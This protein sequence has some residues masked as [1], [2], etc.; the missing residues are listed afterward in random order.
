MKAFSLQ[1]FCA[2]RGFSS[3][4]Y[5]RP[6]AQTAIWLCCCYCLQADRERLK[7]ERA[8]AEALLAKEAGADDAL[9]GGMDEPAPAPSPAP[10][11]APAPSPSP[12]PAPAPAKAAEKPEE[13]PEPATKAKAPAPAPA[14][15][16]AQTPAAIPEGVPPATTENVGIVGSKETGGK[17]FYD[18][19]WTD[20][21]GTVVRVASC[22]LQ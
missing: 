14:A 10:S 12:D 22:S 16:A 20:A 17:T 8:A 5:L 11:P 15:S 21:A 18:I 2:A 3:E 19:R 1:D 4:V 7:A 9:Y 6:R 13:M